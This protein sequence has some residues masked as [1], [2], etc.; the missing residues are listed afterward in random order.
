VVDLLD[1]HVPA[2]LALVHIAGCGVLRGVLRHVP[3]LDRLREDA[4]GDDRLARAGAA[5]DDED[6]LLPVVVRLP[7]SIS[8]IASCSDR[9]GRSSLSSIARI[10]APPSP[11]VISS[12]RRRRSRRASPF[13]NSGARSTYRRYTSCSSS[14]RADRSKLWR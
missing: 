1:E 2:E 3:I 11:T 7:S 13:R 10:V 5:L 8:A 6:P 12:S 14:S 4:D 9:A